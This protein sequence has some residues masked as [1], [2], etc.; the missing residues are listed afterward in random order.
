MKRYTSAASPPDAPKRA[1]SSPMMS[2]S[3]RVPSQ[4]ARISPALRFSSTLPRR[5]HDFAR[6]HI[7]MPMQLQGARKRGRVDAPACA[8][9]GF[10]WDGQ[11]G[12]PGSQMRTRACIIEASA[13]RDIHRDL[14]AEAKIGEGRRRPLH[15]HLLGDVRLD[16]EAFAIER[17]KCKLRALNEKISACARFCLSVRFRCVAGVAA[18][19]LFVTRVYRSGTPHGTTHCSIGEQAGILR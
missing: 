11:E 6:A 2:S 3:S 9:V 4:R 17:R 10:M 7:G 14:E 12:R 5:K 1:S 13:C 19:Y 8:V 16:R 15:V 18:L